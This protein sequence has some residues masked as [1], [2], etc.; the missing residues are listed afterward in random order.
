MAVILAAGMRHQ[1]WRAGSKETEMRPIPRRGLL[2]L[3]AGMLLS[4]GVL[5]GWAGGRPVAARQG[6]LTPDPRHVDE[7][8]GLTWREAPTASMRRIAQVGPWTAYHADDLPSAVWGV[9]IR[10]MALLYCCDNRLGQMSLTAVD[11]AGFQR[12]VALIVHA[13]GAPTRMPGGGLVWEQA[14][15]RVIAAV[16]AAPQLYG[17]TFTRFLEKPEPPV[18]PR[19][20]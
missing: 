4:P 15:L 19:V 9:P 2:P 18:A 13:Y 16:S 17:L 12:V 1:R 3:V 20:T 5:V 7:L 10:E 11:A 14:H 8:L 6:P